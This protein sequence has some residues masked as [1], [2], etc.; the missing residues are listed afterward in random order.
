MPSR[1]VARTHPGRPDNTRLIGKEGHQL[2]E[3]VTGQV[4]G[5]GEYRNDHGTLADPWERTLERSRKIGASRIIEETGFSRSAVY[6]V[7]SGAIPH[8]RRWRTV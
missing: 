7:L 3:G 2:V 5:A 4:V 8:P 1:A 6:G